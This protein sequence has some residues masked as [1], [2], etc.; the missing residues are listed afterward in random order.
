MWAD[1]THLYHGTDAA[2]HS[3]NAYLLPPPP[4]NG[5]GNPYYFLCKPRKTPGF[6]DPL[7]NI[8][9]KVPFLSHVGNGTFSF[10]GPNTE[11]SRG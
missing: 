1:G 11:D 7:F 10:Y 2:G 6:I 4:K 3:M 5:N 9:L 8:C